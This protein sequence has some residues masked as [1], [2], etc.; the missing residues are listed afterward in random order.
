MCSV[1]RNYGVYIDTEKASTLVHLICV[2]GASIQSC[3]KVE[4]L[5]VIYVAEKG[6]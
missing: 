2:F 4:V 3:L 6:I 1:G 5:K